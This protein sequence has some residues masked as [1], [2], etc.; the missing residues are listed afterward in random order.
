MV[1]AGTSFAKAMMIGAYAY[2]P[3]IIGAIVGAVQAAVMDPSSLNSQF[4]IHVGPARFFDVATT[5]LTTLTLMGRFELFTLWST[6]L[7][8][9]GLK[10]TGK[11]DLVKAAIGGALV[12]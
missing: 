1:Q 2:G 12:W 6:I 10:V 9:I 8:A 5:G 3:R 4:A 7:I 11:L